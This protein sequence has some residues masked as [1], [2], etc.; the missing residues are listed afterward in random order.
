MAFALCLLFFL[1]GFVALV[2][3]G[4]HFWEVRSELQNAADSAALAGARDL[5]GTG[6]QFGVAVAS[7]HNYG[8]AHKA[9]GADVDV[10]NQDIVL[11]NWNFN[12]RTFAAMQTPAPQVNAVR[13]T[14]RRTAATGD[15]VATFFAPILGIT[16]QDITAVAVAVGGSP[17]STC[18]FPLAVPDCSLYDG[19]GNLACNSVLRFNNGISDNVAFTLM[20]GVTPNTPDIECAMAKT[21]GYTPCP[22]KSG[23]T[24]DTTCLQTST[25]S[26]Q[27]KI[28]NGN[29][30]SDDMITYIDWAVKRAGGSLLVQ[31]PV[32]R[33]G[34][35]VNCGKYVLSNTETISGY[36]EMRI[37]GA[38]KGPPK[39]LTAIV[40]CTMSG[41][42]PPSGGFYGYKSTYVYITQ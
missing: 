11:G 6:A 26:G 18:G 31:M 9:N 40:D 35:P 20:S 41:A 32:I 14:T 2:V 12:T 33:T 39:E 29:N 1:I 28:S 27:I 3:D 4:G 25:E 7:A 21:L 36:V 34:I 13:V 5:N 19:S 38:S 15:A 22:K 16:Q 23:C 30:F 42:A 17:N 37:T 24:C 10:P 8:L